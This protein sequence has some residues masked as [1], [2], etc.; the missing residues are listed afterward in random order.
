MERCELSARVYKFESFLLCGNVNLVHVDRFAF[1]LFLF[2]ILTH[3]NIWGAYSWPFMNMTFESCH[4][5]S[6]FLKT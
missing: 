4:E 2:N 6:C 3:E 1:G 5:K